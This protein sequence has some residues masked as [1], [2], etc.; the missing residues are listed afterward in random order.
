MNYHPQAKFIRLCGP[1]AAQE[2]DFI[3]TEESGVPASRDRV[4]VSESWW[5]VISLSR[6]KVN[7]HFVSSAECFFSSLVYN[8]SSSY[9]I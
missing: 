6:G 2:Q 5:N 7:P 1:N 8:F 9:R 3:C 4:S